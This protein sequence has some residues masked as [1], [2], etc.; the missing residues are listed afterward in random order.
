MLNDWVRKNC[1]PNCFGLKLSG[2]SCSPFALQ[3]KYE[4]FFYERI[5]YGW[6]QLIFLVWASSRPP[7]TWIVVFFVNI[8][9]IFLQ[10][11]FDLWTVIGRYN[12]SI[13]NWDFYWSFWHLMWVWVLWLFDGLFWWRWNCGR[14]CLQR[15]WLGLWMDWGWASFWRKNEEIFR[16]VVCCEWLKQ[17]GWVMESLAFGWSLIGTDRQKRYWF[18]N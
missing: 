10:I 14:D 11:C 6:D 8:F 2:Y 9:L 13:S 5:L 16:S 1:C 17:T 3:E 15:M 12:F 4:K 18:L 7:T